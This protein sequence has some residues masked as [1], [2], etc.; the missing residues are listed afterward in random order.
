MST[1][2]RHDRPSRGGAP[3]ARLRLGRP[4]AEGG[5]SSTGGAPTPGRSCSGECTA[6]LAG[7]REAWMT[8]SKRSETPSITTPR[9]AAPGIVV[10]I[11]LRHDEERVISVF[12]GMFPAMKTTEP[13]SPRARANAAANPARRRAPARAAR[14]ARNVCRARRAERDRRLFHGRVE[15]LYDGLH[16]AHEKRQPDED[17]RDDDARPREREVN[18]RAARAA[19]RPSR[20]RCRRGQRHARDRRREGQRQVD[21]GVDDRACRG[22]RSARAPR[23]G[24]NPKT[25]LMT[26]P[27]AR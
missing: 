27:R 8:K 4:R 7:V 15:P 21:Y 5:P 24:T 3:P 17:Q 20:C 10:L 22:T 9:L 13:Y 14:R 1:S 16:G 26:R 6:P 25:T 19:S 11:E 23:P 18:A 2:A 12:I